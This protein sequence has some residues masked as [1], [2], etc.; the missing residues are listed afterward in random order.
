MLNFF[1]FAGWGLLVFVLVPLGFGMRIW[2]VANS[3]REGWVSGD[4]YYGVS[5]R[6]YRRETPFRF[7]LSAIGQLGFCGLGL[8]IWAGIIAWNFYS[9]MRH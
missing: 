1:L 2:Q 8:A 3:M 7:W 4:R 6:R 9:R 5:T